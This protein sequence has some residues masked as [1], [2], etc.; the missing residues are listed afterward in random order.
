[1]PAGT[2]HVVFCAYDLTMADA[3]ATIGHAIDVPE[4]AYSLQVP[5]LSPP[6]RAEYTCQN[7]GDQALVVRCLMRNI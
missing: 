6:L 5:V 3:P 4:S 1:M 7:E 2:F